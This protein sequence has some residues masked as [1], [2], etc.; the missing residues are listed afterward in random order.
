MHMTSDE[1]LAFQFCKII[2]ILF[3]YSYIIKKYTY[4]IYDFYLLMFFFFL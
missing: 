2:L 4:S 3:L 1:V